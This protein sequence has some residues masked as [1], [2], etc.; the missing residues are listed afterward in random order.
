VFDVGVFTPLIFYTRECTGFTMF[1][2]RG[3]KRGGGKGQGVTYYLSVKEARPD[4]PR[5]LHLSLFKPMW[6]VCL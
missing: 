4:T 6:F 2:H 5:P 1:V 3:L